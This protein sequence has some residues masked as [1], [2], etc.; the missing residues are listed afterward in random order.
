MILLAALTL[1]KL[2]ASAGTSIALNVMYKR[3]TANEAADVDQRTDENIKAYDTTNAEE[4]KDIELKKLP[5]KKVPWV[6][7]YLALQAKNELANPSYTE[8]NLIIVHKFINKEMEKLHVRHADRNRILAQAKQLVFVKT[9][10]E[11]EVD[12]GSVSNSFQHRLWESS[13]E[14]WNYSFVRFLNGGNFIQEMR[15][16]IPV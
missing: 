10:A 8:A 13:A 16:P 4:L 7:A 5:A 6:A 14:W 2:I 9:K 3:Y 15:K 12:Q 11:I 1:A